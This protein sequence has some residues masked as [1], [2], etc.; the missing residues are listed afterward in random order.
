MPPFFSIPLANH[1]IES[2]S[3]I[4]LQPTHADFQKLDKSQSAKQ[5]TTITDE[6]NEVLNEDEYVTLVDDNG[7]NLPN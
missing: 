1:V 6:L 7:N 2:R 4:Y 3:S 5:F